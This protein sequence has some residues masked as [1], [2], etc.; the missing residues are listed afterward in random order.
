MLFTAILLC[1]GGAQA[2]LVDVPSS[3]LE[4]ESGNRFGPLAEGFKR[5][6][7]V[8]GGN[9][10]ANP[11]DKVFQGFR[12]D[13]RLVLGVKLNKYLALETGFSFLADE[14]FHRIDTFGSGPA[15]A[16]VA[17]GDLL[18][19]SHTTY[20]AAKLSIP[21]IE[22]LSAY[23]KVGVAHSIVKNDS[24]MSPQRAQAIAAGRGADIGKETGSG[25]YGAIGARYKL[26]DRTTVSGEVRS[27][28]SA[29]P[30]G[31]A[32]NASGV[33]GSVGIGF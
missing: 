17:A 22:R 25:P 26:N 29:T 12:T 5:Y 31:R 32:S 27:N 13:P 1:A 7:P 3:R 10:S 18:A 33:R 6:S 15:E 20:A 9:E 16:A 14:G 2:Q 28:G 30:F 4:A 21:V 19:K 11:N 23:G 24:F 8:Y